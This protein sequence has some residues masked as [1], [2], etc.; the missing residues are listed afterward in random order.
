MSD[1]LR[2]NRALILAAKL[3]K[4]DD[5]REAIQAGAELN[6]RDKNGMTALL[7][8]TNRGH[9]KVV[10]LL[11]KHGAGVDE[12][13][14]SGFSPALYAAGN[15]QLGLAAKLLLAGARKLPPVA[16][17]AEPQPRIS[18]GTAAR[19]G[20]LFKRSEKAGS[21][22]ACSR[23]RKARGRHELTLT[24]LQRYPIW[25]I[26][27]DTDD[28]DDFELW[29]PLRKPEYH[30][31]EFGLR[32]IYRTTFRLADGSEVTGFL[33]RPPDDSPGV[34]NTAPVILTD[35][36]QVDLWHGVSPPDQTEE[37]YRMLG[38][39]AAA[40][41]PLDY[42]SEFGRPIRGIAEGF[43][44]FSPDCATVCWTR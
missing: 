12:A 19:L 13:D 35:S 6:A 3:G 8:A 5:L 18:E 29:E 31:P 25:E 7:H 39:E 32:A 20:K 17:A 42:R 30:R 40:V 33:E 23:S 22:A 10:D 34:P 38:R 4:V 1:Q 21:P 44:Y 14:S 36:G 2:L 43:C 15:G 26:A 37:Y 27:L 24:D 11:L 16:G 9:G 28:E 41:F